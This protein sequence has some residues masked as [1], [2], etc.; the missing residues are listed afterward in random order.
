MVFSHLRIS[1][2]LA[3]VV[4]W[5]I[6]L[7]LPLQV[8]S[9]FSCAPGVV[10]LKAIMDWPVTVLKSLLRYPFIASQGYQH[11]AVID[12]VAVFSY[13]FQTSAAWFIYGFV[14]TATYSD[15]LKSPST[16]SSTGKCS[17][18]L[19]REFSLSVWCDSWRIDHF[20][21]PNVISL[22]VWPFV[23][24]LLLPDFL[25]KKWFF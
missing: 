21:M 19:G 25:E 22:F 13:V 10:I 20:I 14:A 18:G 1:V 16:L 24:K 8:L 9:A 11:L 3:L 15:N 2:S 17:T 5:K 4:T 12:C 6:A 7:R 23:W